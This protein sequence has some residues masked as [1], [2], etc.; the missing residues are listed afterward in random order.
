MKDKTD[1]LHPRRQRAQHLLGTLLADA[2][3]YRVSSRGELHPPALAELIGNLSAAGRE[4]EPAGEP[5][6]TSIHDFVDK[7][8]GKVAPYGGV[9]H[10]RQHWWVNVGTDAGA[11]AVESIRRWWTT[12][13]ADIYPGTTRLMI[14][15]D[16]GGSNGSR[17]RLWKT[18][19]ATLAGDIDLGA[20]QNYLVSA[21]AAAN[22][23]HRRAQHG[24]RGHDALDQQR[25]R[26]HRGVVLRPG[27]RQR[28]RRA[29]LR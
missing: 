3:H 6:K 7:K 29:A 11:F 4:W 22:P 12:M 2:V 24:L 19:L 1:L 9:R 16:S 10:R 5:T 8:L 26:R 21:V 13:G 15:A 18:E 27:K 25:L 28:D 23:N 20:T 17:L 14:T